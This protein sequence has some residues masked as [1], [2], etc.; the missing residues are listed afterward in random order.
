M[1]VSTFEAS[2][3]NA[4]NKLKEIIEF[5]NLNSN[6]LEAHKM[7]EAIHKKTLEIGRNLM[8]S[9]FQGIEN[10]DVGKQII[11]DDGIVYKRHNIIRKDYF[12]VFGKFEIFRISYNSSGFKSII[13]LDLQCNLP[14]KTYS[15]YLQ[16][17]MNSLSVQNSFKESQNVLK[18]ALHIDIYD[19]PFI[20]VIGSSSIY[21]DKYYL[22]KDV[23]NLDNEGEIQVISLDG[24]GVPMIKKEAAKIKA[25]QGK[26][27]KRQ[28]KKE[29]LVGVSYTVDKH[30]RTAEKIADNL[31]FP[32]KKELD[33]KKE[34]VP[35][36]QNIRR[37][38]SLIKP[39]FEVAKEIE[40]DAYLRNSN[41]KRK[42]I[43]LID[44]MPS[45]QK[46]V[47]NNFTKITDYTIILDIIHVLE[48]LYIVAHVFF[49]E[50]SPEAK[51]YVHKQLIKILNGN[52]GRVIGGIKQSS[53]K[54]GT[55]GSKLLAINKVIR[56]LSNHKKIM[57]YDEYI[58]QGFPIGT[59]VVESSCK[60]LVKDRM[61]GSGRRWSLD[62]AEAML[63]LR[64]V[65]TSNDFDDYHQFYIN[66]E[67]K[68]RI[69]KVNYSYLKAC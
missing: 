60:T 10:N 39:K 55:K 48:Y 1:N 25:R 34:K 66:M 13:P 37:M 17:I 52:V 63:K 14:E 38:A 15:Y 44:G 54:K 58:K 65:K 68:K 59:G 28:K 5:V 47:E 16:D 32:K 6:I 64:S 42:N 50:S 35:K 12:S 20:D 43:V 67:M 36:G 8:E 24:K 45:L 27:E 29:A 49:K 69:E 2:I 26:G 53:T 30:I 33:E 46:L 7:E 3:S 9:Y 4:K 56:Y 57:K 19:K 18:K 21:Y 40:R 23:S 61:E 51:S 62:G 11:S 41:N 22:E 31:I